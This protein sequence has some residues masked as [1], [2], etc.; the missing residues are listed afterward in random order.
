MTTAPHV[1]AR[2]TDQRDAYDYPD[3]PTS[4]STDVMA[5]LLDFEKPLADLETKLREL[6]LFEAEDG[7]VDLTEQIHALERRVDSLR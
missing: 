1:G 4:R 2:T 3:S 5:H 6:R 7:T